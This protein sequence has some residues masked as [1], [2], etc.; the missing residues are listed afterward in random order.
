MRELLSGPRARHWPDIPSPAAVEPRLDRS[1]A[2]HPEVDCDGAVWSRRAL[3]AEGTR[4]ALFNDDDCERT[5]HIRPSQ[6]P[7]QVTRWRPESG[8]VEAPFEIDGSLRLSLAPGELACWHLTHGTRT[9]PAPLI[10]DRGWLLTAGAAEQ[11][12]DVD[13]GWEQQGWDRYSGVGDY[14]NTFDL[15]ADALAWPDWELVLPVVHTSAEAEIN[16]QTVGRWGWAPFRCDIASSTLRPG[17]NELRIRVSSTAANHYY[18][19]T[20]HQAGP[21]DP[22][23]LAAAP[24]LRPRLAGFSD[25][26]ERGAT[27]V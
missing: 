8:V 5:V 18:A 21:A 3:D 14:R 1:L 11:P 20:R 22:S 23:G 10:L 13:R 2:G 17:P 16:G 19:G 15:T 7:A 9:V 26:S 4:I 27:T 12:V 6:L 25:Q 24:R